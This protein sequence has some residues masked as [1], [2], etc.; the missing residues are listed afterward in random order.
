MKI[1]L[2]PTT[3]N[4]NHPKVTIEV[5]GEDYQINSV[6]DDLIKPLLIAWG[7]HPETVNSCFIEE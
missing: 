4:S 1:T 6:I 2:E 7:F 3:P 5:P